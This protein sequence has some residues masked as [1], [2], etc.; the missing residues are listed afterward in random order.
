MEEKE[1]LT[2]LKT[3]AFNKYYETI[4]KKLDN[5]EFVHTKKKRYGVFTD[6]LY[7]GQ[8]THSFHIRSV[9]GATVLIEVKCELYLFYTGFG[10]TYLF[11]NGENCSG[12]RL[13]RSTRGKWRTL[14]KR[15]RQLVKE[16]VKKEK[17]KKINTEVQ[18]SKRRLKRAIE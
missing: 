10:N 4:I 13:H 17:Q 9:K 1:T 14:V 5:R 16:T 3:Q 2:D 8:L 11:I 6:P 15:C 18:N 7:K 12:R